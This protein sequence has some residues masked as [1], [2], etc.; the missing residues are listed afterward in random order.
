MVT[1]RPTTPLQRKLAAL[2]PGSMH[3]V[4]DDVWTLLAFNSD[5]DASIF[6]GLTL[7]KDIYTS[8]PRTLMTVRPGDLLMFLELCPADNQKNLAKFLVKGKIA[9]FPLDQLIFSIVEVP[10]HEL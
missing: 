7:W 6:Y 5:E 9:H 8:V 10:Q 4:K 1:M 3:N 2:K